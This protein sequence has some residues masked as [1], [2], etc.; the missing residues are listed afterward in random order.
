MKLITEELKQTLAYPAILMGVI[1]LIVCC[2]LMLTNNL[3]AQPIAER[4]RE[5]LTLLLNQVLA[6]DL[7]DNDPLEHKYQAIFAEKKYAFYRAKK[8]G[9][10]SAIILFTKSAGY[11]GDISLIIAIK[12][13]GELSGVRVLSHT[14][15][16]GLGD[17]IELAKSDW[18]LDFNGLSL[19]TPNT[20]G[21][22]VTKDGG[23]F[24]AFT[25]ATITPRAVVNGVFE[26]LMLF[27]DNQA[28]FLENEQP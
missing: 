26:T 19:Q 9:S 25:G 22:A 1:S 20:S 7:Y 16:P 2:L 14:E 5:D 23:Q 24:D 18:I 27:K 6:T 8:Q 15:T 13:D 17:K 10:V 11:S 28:F 3:T 21:W 12:A 4:Q